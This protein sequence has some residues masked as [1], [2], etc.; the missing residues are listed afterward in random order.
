M[1][2]IVWWFVE[3]VKLRICSCSCCVVVKFVGSVLLIMW[4]VLCS[5]VR[6]CNRM[7]GIVLFSGLV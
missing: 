1:M 6:L 3:V 4:L 2:W 7:C 5:C